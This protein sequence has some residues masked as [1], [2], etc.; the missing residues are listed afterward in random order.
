MV[1]EKE[2][3][4]TFNGLVAGFIKDGSFFR[5]WK[6]GLVEKSAAEG[7]L[8]SFDSL[9]KSFPALIAAGAARAEDENTR[10]VLAAN[11]F[12]ECGEGDPTRTHHAIYRKFLK[13]AGIEVVSTPIS[14]FTAEWRVK[15]SEYIHETSGVCGVIGVLAAGE[16][17]AQPVLGLIYPILKRHYPRA[18]QEYFTKHLVLE[19][20]HVT[21]ITGLIAYQMKGELEWGEVLMGF[22]FGLSVWEDYFRHLTQFV[23]GENQRNPL[24]F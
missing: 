5:L 20:K 18:D 9:V 6:E 3:T 17:L 7:F 15:L 10:G 8:I 24:K 23:F 21:E 13:T 4:D 19:T 11:L 1:S 22:K 12:Q 2:I 16:F 14:P